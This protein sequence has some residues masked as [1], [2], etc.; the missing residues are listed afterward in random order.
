MSEAPAHVI[1]APLMKGVEAL[2]VIVIVVLPTGTGL[3]EIAVIVGP[4]ASGLT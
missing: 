4:G 3:G 1:E 2:A